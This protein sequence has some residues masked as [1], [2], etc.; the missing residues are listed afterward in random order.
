M[1]D[2]RIHT[3]GAVGRVAGQLKELRGM[4]LFANHLYVV[5][6]FRDDS[7]VVIFGPRNKTSG[8]HPFVSNF[9]RSS[10]NNSA[11]SHPYGIARDRAGNIYI[12]SQNS[13]TVTR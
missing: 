13:G 5:N 12:S 8:H 3:V 6:S 9:T 10:G 2:P 11:L 7:R 1:R 4:L